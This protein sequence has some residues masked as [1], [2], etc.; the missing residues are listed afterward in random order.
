M[1]GK[2]VFVR[3]CSGGDIY[4]INADGSNELRLTNNTFFDGQP[5]WSPDGSKIVFAS[6]R[7]GGLNEIYTMNADGT[8]PTRLT[9]SSDSKN[10]PAWSSD[11]TKIAFDTA[12]QFSGKIFVMDANGANIRQLTSN[13]FPGIKFRPSWSPDGTKIVFHNNRGFNNTRIN[14]IDSACDN[15][16]GGQTLGRRRIISMRSGRPM[17]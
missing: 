10:N 4:S 13:S 12:A 2:I 1:F 8:N 17:V 7:A 14:V 9:N 5:R 3:C 15:C 16:T 6:D 11:G